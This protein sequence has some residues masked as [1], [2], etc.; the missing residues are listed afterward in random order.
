MSPAARRFGAGDAVA[1]TMWVQRWPPQAE[2]L[3][4]IVAEARISAAR[5]GTLYRYA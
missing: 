3:A 2:A 1:Y 5:Q 4:A